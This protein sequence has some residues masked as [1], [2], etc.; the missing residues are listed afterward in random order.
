[1][2][3]RMILNETSYFGKGAIKEIV[4]EVKNRCLKKVMVAS[5]PD[6]VKFK[7]TDKVTELLAEAGIA[8]A[9]YDGIKPNPTIENVQ[10]GVAFC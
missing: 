1:M 9:V 4:N 6:L 5:D 8:Y 7:V 2:A 10:E 3:N